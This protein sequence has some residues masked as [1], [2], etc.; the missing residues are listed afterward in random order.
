MK[1]A[2]KHNAKKSDSRILPW[3]HYIAWNRDF[4]SDSAHGNIVRK[5]FCSCGASRLSESNH[6][7][8]NYGPWVEDS[9]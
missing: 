7:L 6:G 5:D 9:K 4:H 1:M 3:F 2:H 8:T